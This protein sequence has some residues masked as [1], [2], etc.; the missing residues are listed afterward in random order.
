MATVTCCIFN[1]DFVSTTP[2]LMQNFI[3]I[4]KSTLHALASHLMSS[5]AFSWTT[6]L[7]SEE[8]VSR[9][10]VKSLLCQTYFAL[11]WPQNGFLEGHS[12]SYLSAVSVRPPARTT[13]WNSRMQRTRLWWDNNYRLYS[14]IGLREGEPALSALARELQ[15]NQ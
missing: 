5:R 11:T 6:V 8:Q 12:N 3:K 2:Y 14:C 7:C 4:H 13:R 10:G 1:S 15:I 9:G